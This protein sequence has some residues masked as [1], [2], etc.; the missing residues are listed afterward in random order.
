[1]AVSRTTLAVLV[2]VFAAVAAPSCQAA[3]LL[4]G[5][6]DNEDDPS[7]YAAYTA[8]RA[9]DPLGTKVRNGNTPEAAES[10]SNAAYLGV[11]RASTVG[12][13][14]KLS[15][16]TVEATHVSAN[17][18]R[19]KEVIKPRTRSAQDLGNLTPRPVNIAGG[20]VQVPVLVTNGA[21]VSQTYEG[22][23]AAAMP[24]AV[25]VNQGGKRGNRKTVIANSMLTSSTAA[26]PKAS[27]VG[28]LASTAQPVGSLALSGAANGKITL[29][30]ADSAVA[31]AQTE[32]VDRLNPISRTAWQN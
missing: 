19:R 20:A 1:M 3:R 11:Y 25:I 29:A 15:F 13:Q 23:T 21:S 24:Q 30:Q 26:A 27:K 9:I 7:G 22:A 6:F 8:A 18:D 2:L 10:T 16:A 5:R 12:G 17:P 4:R 32:K 31:M 14:G 28:S